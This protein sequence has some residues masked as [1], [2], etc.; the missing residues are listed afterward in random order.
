MN[1]RQRLQRVEAAVRPTV[2]IP[3]PGESEASAL[4][5]AALARYGLEYLVRMSFPGGV[6]PSSLD[7]GRS[8]ILLQ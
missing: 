5:R 1:L 4:V 3:H 2:F 8:T 6:D 7:S